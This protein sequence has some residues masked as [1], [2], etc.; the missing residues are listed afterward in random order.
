MNNVHTHENIT[1]N[2]GLSS[3]KEDFIAAI[4]RE[5]NL[6][7]VNKNSPGVHPQNGIYVRYIKRFFD[8]IVSLIMLIILLPVN[9]LL[10]ICTFF[11]VGRPIIF[12][13]TRI[14]KDGKLFEM[15]KFRNMT[16]D[17][18]E[19]GNLLPA[20]QRITKFGKFVRKYS[21][22]ELMNFWSV[23]KGDMS[24]I[25]PRPLPVFFE[26]RYS[27]RHRMRNAVRPG[28][29]CPRVFDDETLPKY[30]VRFEND[31]W[32]VEHVSF[33][34]DI[35]MV[36]LLVKMTLNF[37]KRTNAAGGAGYFVGYDEHGYAISMTPLLRNHPE[38]EEMYDSYVNEKV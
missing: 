5:Q 6:E 19:N 38:Y 15:I 26:E 32:Y 13:Q 18:D 14:G 7:N 10:A 36:F 35:K 9:L 16:N 28:L 12:K 34:T 29:E 1:G 3:S 8:I 24:I 23:L 20:S 31:I 4:L 33:I 37:K 30:Q 21:I 17:T 2:K 22:D 25:G 11:D 27:E